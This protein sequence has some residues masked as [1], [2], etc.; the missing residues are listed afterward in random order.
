MQFSGVGG[1]EI[2]PARTFWDYLYIR[3]LRNR[4]RQHMTNDTSKVGLFR[5]V[6]FYLNRPPNVQLFVARVA[7]RR[8]GYLLLRSKGEET[9]IT[10]AVDDRYRRS[11]VGRK[12]VQFAQESAP[13][14]IAEILVGNQASRR[15]HEVT[16]FRLLA[17][18]GRVAE[19]HF[20]RG[21][22]ETSSDL[23]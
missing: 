6:L 2:A 3:E 21:K 8:A 10:E 16:G 1:C 14:L 7:G 22:D 20:T 5:Q 23:A 18:D 11:G 9:F 19:Y 17:E 13:S 15:L 12:M 4:V